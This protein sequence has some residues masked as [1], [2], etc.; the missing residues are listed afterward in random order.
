MN[1]AEVVEPN[2][3]LSNQLLD[4]VSETKTF[5]DMYI[6]LESQFSKEQISFEVLVKQ[7]K[8]LEESKF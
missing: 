4:L 8:K 2:G 6:F 3:P 1:L 5:V 7:I